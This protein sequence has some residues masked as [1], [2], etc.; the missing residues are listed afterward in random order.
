MAII[1]NILSYWKLDVNSA[2]QVDSAGSNDGTVSGATFTTS[3]LINNAYDFDGT[4]D[5]INMG[6]VL[7][8]GTGAWS[9]S[10][11]FKTSSTG[12]FKQLIG[13]TEA[14][15]N[16]EWE[17]RI[18][19]DNKL[20]GSFFEGASSD[21]TTG[22]STVTDGAWH[23][24]VLTRPAAGGNVTLYVDGSSEDSVGNSSYNSTNALDL[25]VGE[26][27]NALF[28]FT[29]IIDEIGIWDKELSS[30]EVTALYNSGNGL[31]YPFAEAAV[32][33]A[34]FHSHNF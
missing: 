31:Q 12:A 26:T 7:D 16:S 15:G 33:N 9:C 21:S 24:V 30:S 2:T 32:D 3:G 4:N 1:D 27:S 20:N 13:K 28:D 23:H 25:V 8:P 19:S 18:K 11:W 5:C 10:M 17:I 29:G 6:D 34:I 22:T 14:D